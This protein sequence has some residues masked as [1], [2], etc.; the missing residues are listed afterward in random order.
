MA[1][2]PPLAAV[3]S[4]PIKIGG[5]EVGAKEID[6]ETSAEPNSSSRRDE[7]QRLGDGH[8][9]GQAIHV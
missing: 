8:L 7:Q 4:L 1:A 2:V 5:K 9:R 3:A 6:S